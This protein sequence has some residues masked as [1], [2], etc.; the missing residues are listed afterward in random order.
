MDKSD[1]SDWLAIRDCQSSQSRH[2]VA[3]GN[4]GCDY[5]NNNS[6]RE[7]FY[8]RVVLDF[9][10]YDHYLVMVRDWQSTTCTEHDTL[11]AG[12]KKLSL[13]LHVLNET[14]TKKF[15]K[16]WLAGLYPAGT[17]TASQHLLFVFKFDPAAR[18]TRKS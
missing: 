15:S 18:P 1:K 9:M 8:S 3:A 2:V 10:S 16:T 4:T 7:L 11:Y 5:N 13:H 6:D 17:C 14:F 12:V